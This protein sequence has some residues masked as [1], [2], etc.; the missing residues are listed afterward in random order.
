ME[1]QPRAGWEFD[2]DVSGHGL[3][4]FWKKLEFEK[5]VPGAAGFYGF[6]SKLESYR[7][8]IPPR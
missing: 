3:L 8:T 4:D 5:I 1:F 6:C 2:F 7:N